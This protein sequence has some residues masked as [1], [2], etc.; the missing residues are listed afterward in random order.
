MRLRAGPILAA[1]LTMSACGYLP[2]GSTSG[3]THIDYVNFVK[4]GGRVYLQS[5]QSGRPLTESDL[6]TVQFHVQRKVAGSGVGP[7]YQPIDGDAAYLRPGTQVYAVRG[8]SPDFRLAAYQQPGQLALFEIS[9]NPQAKTGRDLLDIGGKVGAIV[10]L[11]KTDERTVLGRVDD[12]SRVAGLVAAV[13][14]APVDTRRRLS[15]GELSAFVS[16][17]L[18]DGTATTQPYRSGV[19]ALDRGILV[20]PDFTTAIDQVIATAPTPTPMPTSVNLAERYNLAGAVRVYIKPVSPTPAVMQ[21]PSPVQFVAALNLDLPTLNPV[22]ALPNYYTVVGFEFA[23]HY[24]A[25]AYDP[26]TNTLTVVTPQDYLAVHPA[27]RFRDLV[28][29]PVA[30]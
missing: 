30:S 9:A 1:V 4:W 11:S 14:N 25:F 17:L 28:S 13:L 26:S 16:F 8:Y 21:H 27:Q 10:V 5:W 7:G 12:P 3:A 23:D 29:Q 2:G 20:P 18:L 15:G 6:A 19:L 22:P 24:V